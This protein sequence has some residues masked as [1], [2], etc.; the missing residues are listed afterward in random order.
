MNTK[1][2]NHAPIFDES[3]QCGIVSFRLGITGKKLARYATPIHFIPSTA[4][5]IADEIHQGINSFNTLLAFSE[6]MLPRYF[7]HRLTELIGRLVVSLVSP[8]LLAGHVG[9]ACRW[10]G[11]SWA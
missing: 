11:G 2:G 9:L 6:G 10:L 4:P 1:E 7:M 5:E 8:S 3:P